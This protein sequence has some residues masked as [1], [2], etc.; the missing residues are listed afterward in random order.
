[1]WDIVQFL[2]GRIQA[3]EALF[4]R[5]QGD[6]AIGIFA[7][8][9]DAHVLVHDLL[10]ALVH[11]H[12]QVHGGN[13]GVAVGQ[14]LGIDGPLQLFLPKNVPLEVALGDA[15]IAIVGDQDAVAG[16][17]VRID[18]IG[19]LVDDPARFAGGVQLGDAMAAAPVEDDH[20]GV[21]Q[22][23]RFA[24]ELGQVDLGSL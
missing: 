7:G 17:D 8:G 18:R 2:A 11:F 20:Q 22:K 19:K 21:A 12:D 13:E 10:A 24:A 9:P 14:P 6:L 4:P 5:D 15:V 16:Q 1:N 3:N 23:R